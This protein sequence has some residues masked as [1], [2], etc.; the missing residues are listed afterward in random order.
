MKVGD[1]ISFKPMVS[2]EGEWSNPCIVVREWRHAEPDQSGQSLWVVWV[3]GVE[4]V[5]D[6]DFHNIVYLTSP[7]QDK[8]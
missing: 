5:V 4:A 3:D 1:L 7:L 2:G 8:S 6:T